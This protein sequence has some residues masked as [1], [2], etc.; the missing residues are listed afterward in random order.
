MPHRL[1]FSVLHLS[2]LVVRFG[3]AE[4]DRNVLNSVSVTFAPGSSTAIMGASGSGK[5]TLL[6]CAAGLL[7]PTSGR[8][9]L[10]DLDLGSSDQATRDRVRR[11]NF[12]YIYQEYNLID[13][14]SV[15]QNVQLP[16]FFTQGKLTEQEALASLESVGMQE[17]SR[18]LP[19]S[20]SGGQRQRVAIARALA[21][22]RRVVFADEPTG[23][24]DSRTSRDVVHELTKLTQLGTALVLVTHDAV[25]ASAMDRIL[26]LQDGHIVR[27]LPGGDP[28]AASQAFT[29]ITA[30]A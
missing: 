4:T 28:F 14:L 7:A 13:A 22:P 3:K 30:A 24:L 17:F 1:E 8:V 6:N 23:A 15:I 29:E 26:I 25:V 5:S 18:R 21:V 19:A 27:E 20:L 11:E 9:L 10:D 16:T 12:G 2:D